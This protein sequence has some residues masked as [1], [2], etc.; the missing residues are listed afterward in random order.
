MSST[1]HNARALVVR[2]ILDPHGLL[3]AR[4]QG[5][6]FSFHFFLFI[7]GFPFPVHLFFFFF[8]FFSGSFI[9][10]STLVISA[11]LSAVL[12]AAVVARENEQTALRIDDF[13][14]ANREDAFPKVGLLL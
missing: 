9:F 4:H 5:A 1:R 7:V 2:D 12:T 13:L 6:W 10:H 14:Y 11:T 3:V 8:L